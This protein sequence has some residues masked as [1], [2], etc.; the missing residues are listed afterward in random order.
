MPIRSVH[1]ADQLECSKRK[2][3]MCVIARIE[4]AVAVRAIL[5]HLGRWEPKAVERAP[6]VPRGLAR[7]CEPVSHVS[8]RTLHRLTPRSGPSAL[9]PER[10][11]ACLNGANTG[12]IRH[13]AECAQPEYPESTG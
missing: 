12:S 2:G 6:R 8:Q 3:S 7:A 5:T 1:E 13:Y 10:G 9:T 4:D 11:L